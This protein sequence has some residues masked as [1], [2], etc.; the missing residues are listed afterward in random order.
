MKLINV[1]HKETEYTFSFTEREL[2]VLAAVAGNVSGNQSLE[3]LHDKRTIDY[4]NTSDFS[5]GDAMFI[6]DFWDN[7]LS[8]L[9]G[10]P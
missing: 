9:E 4:L 3:F 7:A 10:K 5:L 8:V 2:K 1:E 6:V